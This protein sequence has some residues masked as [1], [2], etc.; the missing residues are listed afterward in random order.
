MAVLS[1]VISLKKD[2]GFEFPCSSLIWTSPECTLGSWTTLNCSYV[3][4][5]SFLVLAIGDPGSKRTY[6]NCIPH[7][8]TW[9][10]I[11][12]GEKP[13]LM[14]V[15][16]SMTVCW[17][18][19]QDICQYAMAS[20]RNL[21]CNFFPVTPVLNICIVALMFAEHGLAFT[22][23]TLNNSVAVCDIYQHQQSL[24]EWKCALEMTV[25]CLSIW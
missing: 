10:N 16:C 13:S 4:V 2:C 23:L 11:K 15:G 22:L 1:T 20:A 14:L 18:A 19:G 9:I 7:C 21:H 6:N 8:A 24:H 5:N 17:I 25:Q 3:R 12:F